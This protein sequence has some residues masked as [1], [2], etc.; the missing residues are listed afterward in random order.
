MLGTSEGVSGWHEIPLF[1]VVL[2]SYAP[3]TI[4]IVLQNQY[5]YSLIVLRSHLQLFAFNIFLRQH[6]KKAASFPNN[7]HH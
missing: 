5:I 6:T 2:I 3:A 7:G 1:G 4:L